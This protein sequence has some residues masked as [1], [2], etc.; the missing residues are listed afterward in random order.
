MTNEDANIIKNS[1]F[2]K[3]IGDDFVQQ[4]VISSYPKVLKQGE[5]AFQEGDT[6]LGMY[7]V[8]EGLIKLLRYSNDGREMVL[9]IAEPGDC[10]AE[11]AAFLDHYPANALA[12]VKSKVL[13]FP[14][15]ELISLAKSN[16]KF[17][18]F[19]MQSMAKWLKMLVAKIEELTLND[20]TSRIARYLLSNMD[21]RR[22]VV[23]ETGLTVSLQIKKL[24]LAALLNMQLPSLS[25]IMKNLKNQGVIDVQGRNIKILNSQE[26]KRLTLPPLK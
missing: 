2:G 7:I 13:V 4:V 18:F 8:I 6:T 5:F 23:G 15:N 14:K 26:L 9:H 22:S 1:R 25:R 21:D 10:F 16:A 24:E 12:A 19:L 11:A 3:M 20:G 17:S